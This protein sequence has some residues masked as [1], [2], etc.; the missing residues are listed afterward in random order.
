M[1][2]HRLKR[3][4]N[5]CAG[6]DPFQ[7]TLS[8]KDQAKLRKHLRGRIAGACRRR[9]FSATALAKQVLGCTLDQLGAYL[10]LRFK[11]GMSWENHG[12]HWHIDHIRPV[13]S[14]DLSDPEQLKAC[15]HHSNLQPLLVRDNLSKS[16]FWE[17]KRHG[18]FRT[19]RPKPQKEKRKPKTGW[20]LEWSK[21]SKCK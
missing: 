18:K 17:G 6:T 13:A 2:N 11:D 5:W 8:G 16:S 21:E 12:T 7:Q 14:F 10:A 1:D 19:A 4:V 9:S 3:A 20:E 15:F